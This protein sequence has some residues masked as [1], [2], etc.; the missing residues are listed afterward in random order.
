MAARSPIPRHQRPALL[1]SVLVA[2]VGFFAFTPPPAAN[3]QTLSATT[4]ASSTEGSRAA[5]RSSAKSA[6]AI[7][8]HFDYTFAVPEGWDVY[9]IPSMSYQRVESFDARRITEENSG[10]YVKIEIVALPANGLSL[11][12]WVQRQNTESYP[13]PTV[14]EQKQVEVAGEPALYQ[15]EQFGSSVS[16]AYFILKGDRVYLIIPSSADERFSATIRA[17]VA[18]FAFTS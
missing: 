12:A 17:F 7:Q 8:P 14:L 4:T 10:D 9:Q 15:L 1:L 2:L 18:S 11:E 16:Q 5:S 3:G 13:L 6:A